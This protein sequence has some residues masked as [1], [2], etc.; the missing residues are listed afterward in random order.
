MHDRT[1]IKVCGLTTPE[2]IDSAVEAGVDAVGVVLSPS[3]RQVAPQHATELLSRLPGY[4]AAVAVYR[5]PDEALVAQAGEHL[6]PWVLHQSDADDFAGALRATAPDRRVPVLRLVD[7]FEDRMARL[8]DQFVL[9]EGADS[10][11]GDPVDWQRASAWTER[12][13]VVIAGGL[14]P[15]NVG[16]VV[17]SLR[18]FA[19]DVSSGVES[20]PGVKDAGRIRAFVA[21]VREAERS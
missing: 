6:P 7:G 11:A 13:R 8:T 16:E 21:A 18:P 9:I 14:N 4:V 15:A 12:V 19:V 20:S 5:H 2:S 3:P 10:G 17:R 1:R